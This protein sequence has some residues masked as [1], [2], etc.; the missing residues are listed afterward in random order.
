MDEIKP[1]KRLSGVAFQRDNTSHNHE[2]Y[3]RVI[4]RIQFILPLIALVLVLTIM[5]WN[6]FKSEAITPIQERA[7]EIV[8]AN[9][10]KNELINPEFKSIDDKN[11]PFTLT[12]DRAIQNDDDQDLILLEQPNGELKMNSSEIVSIHSKQGTYAQNTQN[13][14]LSDTVE[15]YYDQAYEMNTEQLFIDMKERKAW[16]DVDVNGQG[17]KGTIEAKGMKAQSI[18]D[19]I[20]F[21]GPAK[22]ILFTE[23]NA[24]SFGGLPQ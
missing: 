16:T 22:L 17:P 4:K 15:L 10:G 6:R 11:Q 5:N 7:K 2:K 24:L 1:K 20:I 19:S 18:D 9:I 3:S 21:T 23:D 13:L 12:A 14:F 8:A